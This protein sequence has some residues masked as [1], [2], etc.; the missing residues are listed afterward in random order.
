M[1]PHASECS[2]ASLVDAHFNLHQIAVSTV[3]M[4]IK[5]E[6][7]CLS[8]ADVQSIMTCHCV[9]RTKTSTIHRL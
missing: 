2:K 5:S 7:K 8:E 4:Q 6:V 9:S 3:Q 1:K